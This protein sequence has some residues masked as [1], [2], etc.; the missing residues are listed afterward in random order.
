MKLK[1]SY[2]GVVILIGLVMA[3][4]TFAT[5]SSLVDALLVFAV[6]VLAGYAG[7]WL[8]QKIKEKA[9]R[10]RKRER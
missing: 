10:L 1:R 3:L 7:D 2:Y 9:V 6:V 4:N 8:G 5:G